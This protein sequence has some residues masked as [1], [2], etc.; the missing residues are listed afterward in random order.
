MNEDNLRRLY[1]RLGIGEAPASPPPPPLPLSPP[2]PL[3][4]PPPAEAEPPKES[5]IPGPAPGEEQIPSALE[6]LVQTKVAVSVPLLVVSIAAIGLALFIIVRHS[7]AP[8]APPPRGPVAHAP[9]PTPALPGPSIPVPHPPTTPDPPAPPP[10]DPPTPPPP[11]PPP[12]L[13]PLEIRINRIRQNGGTD[14][15]ESAVSRGLDWLARHQADTG[16]WEGMLFERLCPKGDS[17]QSKAAPGD[18]AYTPGVTGLA[19]LAF[20]GAGYAPA[21]GLYAKNVSRGLAWL[22]ERQDTDGGIRVTGGEVNFYNQA[23]ATRALCEAAAATGDERFRGAAQKALDYLEGTQFPDGGWTYWRDAAVPERNDASIT[24]W[25]VLAMRAGQEAG[26][27][28]S[29]D[30]RSRARDFFLRRTDATTGEVLYAERDPGAGRRGPGLAA[31]GFACR[32]WLGDENPDVAR[33]AVARILA[34]LPDGPKYL[35]AQEKAARKEFTFSLEQNMAGWY[36]GTE[37]MFRRGG[38]DWLV[39]NTALRGLLVDRQ[40][41][42][43]H[44][45]GSWDPETSYIGR[46]GGRVFSTAIGVL[47]LTIYARER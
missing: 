10:V 24:G 47:I 21:E 40:I 36:Y 13:T 45:A 44:R 42:E 41:R 22:V 4:L 23:V 18:Q 17:C 14:Q 12:S 32:N 19:L 37:A 43:T 31:L 28:V 26:L 34:A 20:L 2:P 9:T 35:A 38:A 15:S 25:A 3:T 11:P 33:L 46:E 39:W 7:D 5:A 16:E 27:R 30:M 6:R 29:P 8:P 1:D